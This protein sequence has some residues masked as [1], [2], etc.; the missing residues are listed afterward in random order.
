[1]ARKPTYVGGMKLD[2]LQ[3]TLALDGYIAD[4]LKNLAPYKNSFSLDN[5]RAIS[6]ALEHSK[7][8]VEM[9]ANWMETTDEELDPVILARMMALPDAPPSGR[10]AVAT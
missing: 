10:P 9:T 6:S 7:T 2:A 5:I 4:A 8:V 1:M 3:F